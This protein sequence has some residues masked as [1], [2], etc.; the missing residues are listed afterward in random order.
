MMFGT[1]T[2]SCNVLPPWAPAL[3]LVGVTNFTRGMKKPNPKY[4]CMQFRGDGDADAT[5]DAPAPRAKRSEATAE[6]GSEAS[7]READT[8]SEPQVPRAKARRSKA[9]A[10]A[11]DGA[12][13]PAGDADTGAEPP[14]PR[15]KRRRSKAAVTMPEEEGAQAPVGKAEG[16]ADEAAETVAEAAPATETTENTPAPRAK[17]RRS[18]A[19]VPPEEEG[20]QTPVGKAEGAADEAAET[21]VEAAPATETTENREAVTTEDKTG[22]PSPFGFV[23]LRASHSRHCTANR[24]MWGSLWIPFA[25]GNHIGHSFIRERQTHRMKLCFDLVFTR[26]ETCC[27]VFHTRTIYGAGL[28]AG[29]CAAGSEHDPSKSWHRRLTNPSRPHIHSLAVRL[30]QRWFMPAQ[31]IASSC[32]IGSSE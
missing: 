27:C 20:A 19:A 9:T 10:A 14:A 8:V 24:R 31:S 2:L 13:A 30:V 32:Q 17:R 29:F 1:R 6:E 18:K 5:A 7:A 23:Y 16:A 3:P 25:K 21:V 26:S 28:M 15:A 11:D 4:R 22:K 12:E